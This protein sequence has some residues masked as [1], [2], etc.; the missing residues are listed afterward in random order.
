MKLYVEIILIMFLVIL[1]YVKSHRLNLFAQSIL[2]KITLVITV[3]LVTT[4]YGRNAGVLSAV[5]FMLLL[6]TSYEGIARFPPPPP[7]PR[8]PGPIKKPV[9]KD[10]PIQKIKHLKP[11]Q[12]HTATHHPAASNAR[13]GNNREGDSRDPPTAVLPGAQVNAFTNL[14]ELN[15][16]IRIGSEYATQNAT[17]E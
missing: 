14:T 9:K 7:P 10:N 3:L 15:R 2:G 5:I 4:Q 16:Q 12:R 11:V 8:D 13:D 17:A 6:H 1:M